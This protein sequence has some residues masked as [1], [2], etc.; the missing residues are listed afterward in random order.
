MHDVLR[1]RILRKLEVL[2]AAQLYQVLDYI[3]FLE[4]KY[5]SG[6]APEPHGLQ[7]FA[8]RLEDRMR[9]RTVAPRYIGGA[10]SAL[11]AAG[12]MVEQIA[13]V[14]RELAAEWEAATQREP[15]QQLAP[16]ASATPHPDGT[17]LGEARQ[18]RRGI[19]IE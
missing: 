4:S 8:E 17:D 3:E 9:A 15:G 10:M 7:R 18:Q 19:A 14:G 6:I 12:R 5:A 2:P 16:P 1:N 13:G 11:G